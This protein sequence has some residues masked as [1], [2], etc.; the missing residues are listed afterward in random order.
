LTDQPLCVL[1]AVTAGACT[2]FLERIEAKGVAVFYV[3][4]AVEFGVAGGGNDAQ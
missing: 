2:R 1:M 3:R 4:A